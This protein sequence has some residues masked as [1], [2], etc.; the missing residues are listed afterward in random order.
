MA[1]IQSQKESL[2]LLRTCTHLVPILTSL[3]AGIPA[4]F[5]RQAIMNQ[6]TLLWDPNILHVKRQP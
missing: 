1:Y 4:V 3:P 2:L 5:G 6:Q